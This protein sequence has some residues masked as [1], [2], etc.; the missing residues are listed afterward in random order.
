MTKCYNCG[1]PAMYLVGPEGKEVPLCLDCNLKH[2]QLLAIKNEQLEKQLNYLTDEME[3]ALGL[4]RMSP[5]YPQ[6]QVKILQG[7]KIVLNNIQVS[8]SNI[9][10]LN[11]GDLE[12]VDSAITVLNQDA[13]TREVSSAIFKLAN[14]IAG[15]SEL[16]PEKK[17]E[18]MEILGV[19]ASEA[20]VPK[21][22]RRDRVVRRLLSA[23]PT[24]IQTV[25][26]LIQIW[27]SVE[28]IIKPYF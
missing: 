14:A 3:F 26:S 19:I 8:E 16:P 22:K 28:P 6:R 11:T 27:Q 21:E 15:S 18:A 13:S 5:R 9:G 17:N 12:I 25:A 4:P 1:K 10:V 23:L 2:V 7:G 20:T 24:V